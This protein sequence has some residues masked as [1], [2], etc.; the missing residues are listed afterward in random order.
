MR[1]AK[2][3]LVFSIV[4]LA[5]AFITQA[6]FRSTTQVSDQAYQGFLFKASTNVI[7][8]TQIVGDEMYEY[9][10]SIVS[11]DD[12][13]R[14]IRD[15]STADATILMS[16]TSNSTLLMEFVIPEP[17]VYGILFNTS[18]SESFDVFIVINSSLPH[19]QLLTLAAIVFCVSVILTAGEVLGKDHLPFR[20]E[21]QM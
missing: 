20:Q 8:E 1:I 4:L 19:I 5:G 15:G 17:G 6:P 7:I 10:V 18:Q 2:T 12:L 11:V 14:C 9:D 13:I 16:A 3:F 21:K